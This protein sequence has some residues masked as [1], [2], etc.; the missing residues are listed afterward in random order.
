MKAKKFD[1]GK[2]WR[3]KPSKFILKENARNS[4]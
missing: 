3:A 4:R 1:A 2:E